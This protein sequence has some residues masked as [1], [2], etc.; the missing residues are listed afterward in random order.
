VVRCR[1]GCRKNDRAGDTMIL[2]LTKSTLE[3]RVHDGRRIGFLVVPL[4]N[5]LILNH[6]V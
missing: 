1:I 6:S 3:A 2:K 5:I 4:K